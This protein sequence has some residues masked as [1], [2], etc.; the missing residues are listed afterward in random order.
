MQLDV[1]S[2]IQEFKDM[3]KKTFDEHC[4]TGLHTVKFQLLHHIVNDLKPFG[5]SFMQNRPPIEQKNVSI[6]SAYCVTL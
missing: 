6:N 1:K 5:S 2:N 4:K 3:T